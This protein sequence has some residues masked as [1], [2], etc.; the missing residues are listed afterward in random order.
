MGLAVM[1]ELPVVIVNVQRGGPSTGLPTK[2]EQADLLQALYGRNGE[3][4]IPVIAASSPADC[5]NAAVEAFAIATKYMTPVVVLSDGYIANGAEP[6]LIP[7]VS[8][9]PKIEIK[10]PTQP[11]G[12]AGFMPYMRDENGSRPWALPG[13][14]GLEHR[15][16]GLEKQD[17]TGNVSYD[18][19][20]HERM[21]RLR[22]DKIANLDAA[23]Q[24]IL[25][26]GPEKGDVLIVGWGSTFGAIKAATLELRR[27]GV[28]VSACHV[29]YLNPLPERLGAM[30][31]DFEHVL[32]PEMNLGQLRM[33]LR[34][35]F[36]IDIKGLNKVRGQ[37]FT[38]HEIVSGVQALLRGEVS[39][40]EVRI[41]AG[42]TLDARVGDAPGGG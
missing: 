6:W 27:I 11:E 20:N 34:N 33:L 35:R 19:A 16:G 8:K 17:V 3:C 42:D 24:E 7:D 23:G 37:P 22:A 30:M 10:H 1:V 41:K 2:T 40:D 14:P 12:D 25:W 9:L 31:K 15:I 32:I 5:F 29:R 13:T 18:P 28:N 26:T 39:G 36:L 4:P 21:I 38:I